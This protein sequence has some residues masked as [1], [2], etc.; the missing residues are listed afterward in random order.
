M[1]NSEGLWGN[2]VLPEDRIK[3]N[4]RRELRILARE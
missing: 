4:G 3:D 2:V 1:R